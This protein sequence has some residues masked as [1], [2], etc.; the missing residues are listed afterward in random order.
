MQRLNGGDQVEFSVAGKQAMLGF[1]AE[2]AGGLGWRVVEL[3]L[4]D[5]VAGDSG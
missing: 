5:P 2:R 4:E 3:D 1:L